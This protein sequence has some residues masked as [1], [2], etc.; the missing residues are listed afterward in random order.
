VRRLPYASTAEDTPGMRIHRS[1]KVFVVHAPAK[2]N[3]F[4]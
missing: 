1:A 2:V 3:L 4:F